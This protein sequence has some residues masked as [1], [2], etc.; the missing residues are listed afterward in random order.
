MGREGIEQEFI[1]K[2]RCCIIIGLLWVIDEV[3][4]NLRR[5]IITAEFQPFWN[6]FSGLPGERHEL[7]TVGFHP[8]LDVDDSHS[9]EGALHP[10]HPQFSWKILISYSPC[11]T[12][13][14]DSGHF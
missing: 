1:G 8:S 11:S 12:E 6:D 13:A 2:E 5:R 14:T 7:T 9:Q 10:P 3:P 4:C